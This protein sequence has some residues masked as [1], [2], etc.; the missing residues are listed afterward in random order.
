MFAVFCK[1]SIS[2]VKNESHLSVES[3]PLLRS[4]NQYIGGV[5][6]SGEDS[7]R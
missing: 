5:V 6:S 3:L 2:D 4:D 1:D 7:Q